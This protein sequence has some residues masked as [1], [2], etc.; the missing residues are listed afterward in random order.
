MTIRRIRV[1]LLLCAGCVKQPYYPAG[2]PGPLHVAGIYA[3]EETLY[4]SDCPGVAA[5]KGLTRVEVQHTAGATTL[6]MTVEAQSFDAHIRQDG[7]FDTK[8]FDLI[9]GPVTF[10][11]SMNGRFTDSSFFAR[12]NV[13]STEPVSAARPGMPNSRVCHYQFRWAGSKL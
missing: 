11:T 1:A 2:G 5:K 4:S 10:T 3:M 8:P 9:R 6:K 12:L 13:S 7:S